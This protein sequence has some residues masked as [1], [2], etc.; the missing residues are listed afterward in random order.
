MFD[1][2]LIAFININI[3]FTLDWWDIEGDIHNNG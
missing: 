3:V 1:W 2:M